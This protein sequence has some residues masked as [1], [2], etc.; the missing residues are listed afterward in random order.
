MGYVK[1]AEALTDI[2]RK[3]RI[4]N[5]GGDIYQFR[6]FSGFNCKNHGVLS[7]NEK[8]PAFIAELFC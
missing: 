2:R 4:L 5:F 1:H 6:L 3:N 8:S 7:P